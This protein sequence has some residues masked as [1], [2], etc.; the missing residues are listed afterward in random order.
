MQKKHI[1]DLVTFLA[2]GAVLLGK[3]LR[4]WA[5]RGDWDASDRWAGVRAFAILFGLC[6][7][8]SL[9]L[10]AMIHLALFFMIP[11]IWLGINTLW[12]PLVALVGS[13]HPSHPALPLVTPQRP[14]AS[15]SV[16]ST[17]GRLGQHTVVTPAVSDTPEELD[18]KIVLGPALKGDL[19]AWVRAGYLV[20]P[21]EALGLHG[22]VIG[23]SGAGK[24]ETL[25]RLAYLAAKV[26]GWRVYFVDAKG[27]WSLAARF[28]L[29]MQQAGI[30]DA[31]I[32]MFPN[33][34]HNG[35]LGTPQDLLNKLLQSQRWSEPFYREVATNLL[36]LAL[37]APGTLSPPSSSRELL[38]RL[39]PA[40][41][42]NAY[43]GRPEA[44]ELKLDPDKLL[45]AY[46][47]YAAFF[48]A[49]RGKLD[50]SASFGSFDAGYY[51]LDGVRLKD[52]ATRLGHYLLTDF[53]Q[54]LATKQRSAD[55]RHSLIIVDDYA[56]I[57]DTT[58][59][60]VGLFERI[61]GLGGCILVSAQSEEGL[62]FYTDAR[63]IMGAAPTA[64]VHATSFPKDSIEAAGM[65]LTPQFTYHLPDEQATP[66]PQ[67]EPRISLT[68]RRDF[69]VQPSD[70][71]QLTTGRA[72]I[73]HGGKA[74]LTDIAML[75]YDDQA[76]QKL[77]V[78][79]QQDYL[80]SQPQSAPL[81]QAP[82]KPQQKNP[83][84]QKQPGLRSD[85][86]KLP[87]LNDLTK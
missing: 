35:F 22:V 14:A 25:L 84:G 48:R 87:K 66:S 2:P 27:D 5:L 16:A 65:V 85:T 44:F 67:G 23:R 51:L 80:T 83:S 40:F 1:R 52:E 81:P 24:S 33:V 72:Y 78:D 18:G 45:G 50:G 77:A 12:A 68:M 30:P 69:R 37:R 76:V 34:A 29:L 86:S 61:R 41:L 36:W 20:F 55:S 79:L 31:R 47:R 56:V 71:Q 9:W 59:A 73:I 54:F 13:L 39:H 32:G 49:V 43:K 58:A 53:E 63:R 28:R 17:P 19:W 42:L 60:A 82:A 21:P 46:Y 64:I 38:R 7:A 4:S 11:L 6:W 57:A 10:L 62:G 75:P 15:T 70:V 74:H 3:P 8:A 26:Y